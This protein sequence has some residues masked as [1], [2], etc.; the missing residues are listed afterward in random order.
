MSSYIFQ[1]WH[2]RK[3]INS[4]DRKLLGYFSEISFIPSLID[5]LSICEGFSSYVNGFETNIFKLNMLSIN[6]RQ[7]I[8]T[9]QPYGEYIYVAVAI[10]DREY[11][12]DEYLGDNPVL[13]IFSS[14]GIA[15]ECIKKSGYKRYEVLEYKLGQ[16]FFEDGFGL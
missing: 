6:G 7:F 5:R 1:L 8:E 16:C 13:G 14:K 2:N 12:E 9:L 3:D 10:E 15:T 4:V 11:N